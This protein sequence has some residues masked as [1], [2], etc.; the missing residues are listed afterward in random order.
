V[1]YSVC[2]IRAPDTGRIAPW[3]ATALHDPGPT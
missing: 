3:H 1:L 2:R